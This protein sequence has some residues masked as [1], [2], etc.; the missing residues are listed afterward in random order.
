[1]LRV[2][3]LSAVVATSRD[4]SSVITLMIPRLVP[5]LAGYPQWRRTE[6]FVLRASCC[7]VW[8]R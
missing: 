6:A 1:M 5:Q 3:S 4:M 7:R 2:K 8:S